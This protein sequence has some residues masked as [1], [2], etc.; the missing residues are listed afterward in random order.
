MMEADAVP[1]AALHCY[2]NALAGPLLSVAEDAGF[3]HQMDWVYA[4]LP[5]RRPFLFVDG[6]QA[7]RDGVLCARFDVAQT[8]DLFAGHFPGVP[9]WPGAIQIEAMAQAGLMLYLSSIDEKRDEVALAVVRE[10]RFLREVLP[11]R[12]VQ[13][14]GSFFE[15]GLFIVLVGQVLQG[16]R[17]CSACVL[18]IL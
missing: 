15:D 9:R 17:V 8:A 11:G 16:G 18:A 6:V 5:Q 10:A 12:P 7:I 3:E 2:R 1:E 4:H 13:L 14:L